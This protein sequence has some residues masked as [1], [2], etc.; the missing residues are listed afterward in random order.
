MKNINN[1]EKEVMG[2]FI[3]KLDIFDSNNSNN[4]KSNNTKSNNTNNNNTKSNNSKS[5][6][7]MMMIK[8]SVINKC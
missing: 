5:K 1:D 7:N 4:S 2:S 3:D 8:N 6:K